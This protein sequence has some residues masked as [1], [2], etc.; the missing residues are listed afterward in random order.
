MSDALKTRATTNPAKNM[1][2]TGS[3]NWVFTA[4]EE[5]SS[6]SDALFQ[7]ILIAPELASASSLAVLFDAQTFVESV[8]YAPT[9]VSMLK[10]ALLGNIYEDNTTG[11]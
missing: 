2:K 6:D 5:G 3:G 7:V 11:Q 8:W 10:K 9:S 4:M 1:R